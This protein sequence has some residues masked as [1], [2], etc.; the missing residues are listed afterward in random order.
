MNKCGYIVAFKGKFNTY[1]IGGTFCL[2]PE[3]AE[4]KKRELQPSYKQELVV[5][6]FYK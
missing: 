1:W 3:E 4:Q 6:L 2:T 5:E